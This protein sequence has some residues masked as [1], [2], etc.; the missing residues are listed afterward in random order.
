MRT[1]PTAWCCRPGLP[2]WPR[3]RAATL[4]VSYKKSMGGVDFDLQR[5]WSLPVTGVD[6]AAED[7]NDS[8]CDA[9][10]RL[11]IGTRDPSPKPGAHVG[12]L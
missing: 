9:R 5:T 3:I 8:A 4:L 7:F 10:G 11:W 2:L 6:F 1:A 12:R